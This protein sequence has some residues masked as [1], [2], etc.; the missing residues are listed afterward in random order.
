[1]K[2]VIS[3]DFRRF[4]GAARRSARQSEALD[5]PGAPTSSES[6]LAH[7]TAYEPIRFGQRHRAL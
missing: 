3:R 4:G 6:T 1:V 2:Y 7:V 5:A